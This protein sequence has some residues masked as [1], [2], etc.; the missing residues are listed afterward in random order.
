MELSVK[1]ISND[2]NKL[3]RKNKKSRVPNMETNHWVMGDEGIKVFVDDIQL[4][5]WVFHLNNFLSPTEK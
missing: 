2:M 4:D 1:T 5:N 3:Q